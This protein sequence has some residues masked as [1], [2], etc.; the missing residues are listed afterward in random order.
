VKKSLSRAIA[1]TAVCAAGLS[2]ALVTNT[3]AV[4]GSAPAHQATKAT[5][6]H[7][8]APLAKT[9]F[10]YKADVFGTKLLVDGV[11]VKTLKDGYAQQRC[12]AQAGRT[13]QKNSLLALPEDL[14]PLVHLSL[15]KQE[16][17][18]YKKGNTYGV[19][20]ISTFGDI[21]VG[22]EV[23]GLGKLPELK[24]QGLESVSDAF[25]KNGKFGHKESF[26]FKGISLDYE[27]SVVDNTPLASLLDIL[28]QVLTPINQIVNQVIDLLMSV[29]GNIIEI[30]GLGALGL[31]TTKGS[32]TKHSAISESYALK[33]LINATGNDTVLQLGRARTR[34][35]KIL[36]DAG[37][38]RGTATGLDLLSGTSLHLGNLGQRSIPCEG[39][40]G[41]VQ[42]QTAGHISILGGLVDLTGIT[43][44]FMGLQK[45][46]GM[47]KG[48]IG[49]SLGE[50]SIPTLGL[51]ITG[52]A[53]QV[54]L[55][56]P[57]NTKRVT[58][59][60]DAT[61]AKIMLDGNEISLP[62]IGQT[63]S[64]GKGSFLT[65]RKVK[66]GDNNFFGGAVRALTL[67]LGDLVMPG[68]SII[69]LG[70]SAGRI[71]PR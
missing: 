18:T 48:M 29:T 13:A 14:V 50:I 25:N 7:K 47:A 56:K 10:G 8:G 41:K 22:G 46:N 3:S 51:K 44:K 39:T 27:G 67:S 1:I 65:Y 53:S 6:K 71:F 2:G 43:Y 5:T 9:P 12:T 26:D 11:E 69:D 61:V 58:K 4:A 57:A 35:G 38:F 63:L 60:V 34:I 49:T 64:L 62:A 30:P 19:K 16:S 36:P 33:I 66:P 32:V 40:N 24:I 68:G 17:V 20:G 23:P 45:P 55:L 70:T 21:A 54:N 42:K 15:T 52:L 31:G 59:T 28:N 37:V